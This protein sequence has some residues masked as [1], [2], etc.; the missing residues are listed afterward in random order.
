[1]SK[2]HLTISA[3][4]VILTSALAGCGGGGGDSLT[5]LNPYDPSKDL[6]ACVPGADSSGAWKVISNNNV[7]VP[8]SPLV[9]FFSYNQP[10]I[11]SSGLVVFRGRAKSPSGGAGGGVQRGIYAADV[12]PTTLSIYTVA[13]TNTA[14][15]A[16]NNTGTVFTEFPSIPRIDMDTGVLATRGQSQPVWT[17]PD[18]TKLGTSG[19]YV[20]MPTGLVTGVGL[21]GALT[22]YAYMQVP[23]ATSTTPLRFDQFPGS[24]SMANA[25]YLVFKGNYT[26]VDTSGALTVSKTGVYYRDMNVANS[27]VTVIADSN[28][29]IPGTS[30][31]FGSTAPPSAANG[32]VVFTGLD[33]ETAP[34]LGGI[35]IAP[36]ASKPTLTPLVTIGSPVP[37]SAGVA[38]TDG[39]TFTQFGEG[40]S[41]DGRYV[42]FWGA[43]GTDGTRNVT[44]NCPGDGNA[45]LIAACQAQSGGT[46]VTVLPVSVDQGIFVYDTQ[47]NKVWM[48]ARSGPGNTAQ[49][50]DFLF[51]VFSGN[52]KTT[53]GEPPR[54]RSSAFAAVDGARGV[55][56]KGALST[57]TG[58][59][60]VTPASGLYGSALLAGNAGMGPVFKVVALG[61]D[62]ATLDPAAP[63]ASAITS[64]GIEREALRSGWF[65]LTA[66]SLNAAAESWAGLYATYFSGAFRLGTTPDQYGMLPL[67][68]K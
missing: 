62:M 52:P 65:V 64:L 26:D 60:G 68:L 35:Y 47:Q 41:F 39:S 9:K 61:D 28:T 30:T 40:L 32:H 66:S 7:T 44:L 48:A 37:D 27:P 33:I 13:D 11:N 4:A 1:M 2:V 3:I 38:L 24:P 29:L 54:W 55:I 21:F 50:Q 63:A 12:C 57:P 25:R 45:D 23:N 19:L 6:L 18:G 36:M 59:T 14:V 15:P 16:P 56:F 49:F 46:G 34:T 17:L 53:D 31:L 20:S 5:P 22:D 42:S 8:N 67:V 43:W 51:W 10:S 58:A